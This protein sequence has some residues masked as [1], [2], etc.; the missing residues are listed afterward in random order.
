MRR[1]MYALPLSMQSGSCGR[2]PALLRSA[3]RCQQGRALPELFSARRCHKWLANVSVVV[4]AAH[5]SQLVRVA[6]DPALELGDRDE[7][8]LPGDHD[9]QLGL[10]LALEVVEADAE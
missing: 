1:A 5:L 3:C 10:H 6:L 7:Y 8:Q 2:P 4:H 9:L